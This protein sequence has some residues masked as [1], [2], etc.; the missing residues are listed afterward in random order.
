MEQTNLVVTPD[1]KTWDEVT[2]DTSYIG[3]ST[4]FDFAADLNGQ[5][6]NSSIVIWDLFRGTHQTYR[7]AHNKN[8]AIAGDRVI[9]LEEGR[10]SISY[11]LKTTSAG[12]HS[13]STLR[14]NGASTLYSS[15]DPEGSQRGDMGFTTEFNLKRG[16]Y[17]QIHTT[18]QIDDQDP[19]YN[20]F[21]AR[22][23]N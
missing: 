21:Q 4:S 14:V 17:L 9:C 10:Y 11:H 23:I 7:T 16:D 3:A 18:Y 1:G 13:I 5:T 15:T 19:M 2:R 20:F 22:K 12:S 8:F 6:S